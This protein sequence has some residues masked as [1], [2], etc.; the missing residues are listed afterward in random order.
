MAIITLTTDLGQKDFYLA[1]LKGSIMMQVPNAQI[2]DINNNISSFNISQAAFIL[3]NSY[4][5]FPKRSVHIVGVDCNDSRQTRFL[6]LAYDGHYFVGADNGIFSLLTD[7]APTKMVEIDLRSETGFH[8]FPLLNILAKAACHLANGGV[9]DIL[10]N[11]TA[12]MKENIMLQ[13]VNVQ[14]FLKGSIIYIDGY[15]NAITNITYKL[16]ET[17][18]ANR[19]FQLTFRRGESITKIS[20]Q[21]DDVPEGEKLCLFGI[22][23]HL[24]IAINKGKATSLLGLSIDGLVIIEFFETI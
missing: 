11:L 21:Y 23:N 6:A 16:F 2:V 20:K 7:A 12:H 19:R 18:R 10:G 9:L 13:P 22:S 17:E 14:N 4:S 3:K 15:E 24:E 5:Y 1:A 8:H